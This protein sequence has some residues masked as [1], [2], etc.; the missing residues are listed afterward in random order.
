MSHE[1]KKDRQGLLRCFFTAVVASILFLSHTNFAHAEELQVSVEVYPGYSRLIF[2]SESPIEADAEILNS[3]LLLNFERPVEF[4]LNIIRQEAGRD[5]SRVRQDADGKMLRFAL[6]RGLRLQK[7]SN[8]NRVAIDLLG[9]TLARLPEGIGPKDNAERAADQVRLETLAANDAEQDPIEIRPLPISI[10]RMDEF[11][12]VVFEWP[13]RVGYNAELKNGT[14]NILFDRAADPSLTEIRTDPPK[15]I[16]GAEK[17]VAGNTLQVDLRVETGA[18]VRHFR[19]GPTIVV[20]ILKPAPHQFSDD[21]AP[22]IVAGF[23]NDWAVTELEPAGDQESQDEPAS[24]GINGVGDLD[25]AIKAA[26][27]AEDANR[28]PDVPT[29]ANPGAGMPETRQTSPLARVLEAADIDQSRIVDGVLEAA[30]VEL[31]D[32]LKLIF[33]WGESVP[34]AVFRRG[35]NLWLVFDHNDVSLDLSALNRAHRAYVADVQTESQGTA[36][37]A[38]LTLP[39]TN[40]TTASER[41]GAWIVTLGPAVEQAT[42][43]FDFKRAQD[44]RGQPMVLVPFENANTVHWISD[45][46]IGDDLAVVT[47]LG[48]VRGIISPLSLVEF[49]VLSSAHGLVVQALSDDVVV[50][51]ADGLVQIGRND[52]LT[53]SQVRDLGKLVERTPL[54]ALTEP[55]FMDFDNWRNGDMSDVY[56]IERELRLELVKSE[57]KSDEDQAK[58]IRLGLAKFYVSHEL[59]PEALGALRVLAQKDETAEFNPVFRALRGVANYMQR[60]YA[61]SYDDLALG[62]LAADPHASLWRASALTELSRFQEAHRFFEEGAVVLPRYTPEWQAHFRV[63]AAKAALGIL[64]VKRVKQ[65]LDAMPV[66]NL[67]PE[68]LAESELVRGR[69]LEEIE[70]TGEALQ[71]YQRVL[72]F[73]TPSQ[74]AQAQLGKISLLHRVSQINDEEA[75][76]RLDTLRFQWRGDDLEL[77]VLHRLGELYVEGGNYRQGLNI[78]QEVVAN[79]SDS[80]VAGDIAISMEKIFKGLFLDQTIEDIPPVQSLALYYDYKHLTPIGREGDEMIRKLVDRLVAVDLLEQ[81]AELLEHQVDERLKGVARAQVATRL[82]M[83]YLTDRK[84]EAAL[85]TIRKTRQTRLP[86]SLTYARRLL[87]ARALAELG[88]FDHALEVVAEFDT[89]EVEQLRADIAWDSQDWAN[90]ASILE[91]SLGERWQDEANTLTPEERNSILRAALAY[92]FAEDA[93]SL[94][95]IRRAYGPLMAQTPDA[96]SFD[97]ITQKVELRGV[98]FRELA[99]EIATIDTLESFMDGFQERLDLAGETA[100]N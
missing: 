44:R 19:E 61:E 90:A 77:A 23:D 92:S 65:N 64:D 93:I 57:L 52:G 51:L 97:V 85:Q 55:A 66:S 87:E 56:D 95:R 81:A 79:Y 1:P 73:G 94:E 3:V 34:A 36:R 20:D 43:P 100:I 89:P 5:V 12:R 41:D 8:N 32:T 91:L 29:D 68:T 45:P 98:A 96:S 18:G 39:G 74:Q 17:S 72:Q 99:N 54:G 82:A 16:R 25:P 59:A 28:D 38:R 37:I 53:L 62:A 9:P 75:I 21:A 80:R 10:S 42:V 63:Q 86:G 33:N 4:D 15:F 31:G 24:D 84:S 58:N 50:D 40:L 48:P 35:P 26:I 22:N 47:G 30:V 27:E 78:M 60:R 7:T 88:R 69:W 76:N 46:M 2:E 11:S 13:E 49:N 71:H 70:R 83:V 14:V 6:N 67:P